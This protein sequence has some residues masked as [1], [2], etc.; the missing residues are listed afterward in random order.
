MVSFIFGAFCHSAYFK[1]IRV[2]GLHLSME[3]CP[4]EESSVF[5]EDHFAIGYSALLNKKW[6][7]CPFLFLKLIVLPSQSGDM[8][9]SHQFVIST[10]QNV[11]GIIEYF[12]GC[13]PKRKPSPMLPSFMVHKAQYV[14]SFLSFVASY[15]R[16]LLNFY[17]AFAGCSNSMKESNPYKISCSNS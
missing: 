12:R 10:S 16:L 1:N 15:Y 14:L 5:I 4:S 17:Y 11:R 2:F 8:C 13:I 7:Q 3:V 9:K 6:L